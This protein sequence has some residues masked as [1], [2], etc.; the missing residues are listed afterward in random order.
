MN[1]LFQQLNQNQQIPNRNLQSL[2]SSFKN[3]SNPRE[4]LVQYIQNNP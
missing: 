1:S 2:I 3:S 4:F